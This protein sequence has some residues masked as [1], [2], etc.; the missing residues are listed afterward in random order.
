MCQDAP[1]LGNMLRKEGLTRQRPR[2]LHAANLVVLPVMKR[3][4]VLLLLAVLVRCQRWTGG[5]REGGKAIAAAGAE[6][7]SQGKDLHVSDSVVNKHKIIVTR[8]VFFEQS[9][10]PM[11]LWWG[12]VS[13]FR[14]WVALCA[15][16]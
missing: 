14:H 16:W 5:P 8:S 12:D 4:V 6:H 1:L 9:R 2:A 13:D 3:V 7:S 10:H 15:A 11:V